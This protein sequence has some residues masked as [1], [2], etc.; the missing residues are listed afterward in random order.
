[1]RKANIIFEQ[2]NAEFKKAIYNKYRSIVR[3][4]DG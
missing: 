4:E 1:M 2:L 3:E